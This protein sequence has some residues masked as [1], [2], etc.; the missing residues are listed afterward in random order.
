MI[1]IRLILT[2]EEFAALLAA[3]ECE[4]RSPAEQARMMLRQDLERRGLLARAL[5]AAPAPA[6]ED[7]LR[8]ES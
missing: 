4:L 3:S 5:A 8:D 7:A 2:Q 6:A 1:R